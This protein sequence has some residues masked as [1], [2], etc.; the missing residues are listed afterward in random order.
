MENEKERQGEGGVNDEG[1]R[2]MGRGRKEEKIMWL[3]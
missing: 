1:G 2:K 3:S